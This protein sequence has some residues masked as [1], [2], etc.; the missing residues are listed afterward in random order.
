MSPATARHAIGTLRWA[1]AIFVVA[2]RGG[3]GARGLAGVPS[4]AQSAVA[5]E[6]PPATAPHH[7]KIVLYAGEGSAL[8]EYA[9]DPSTGDL[10]RETSLPLPYP[11]H[12]AAADPRSRFLYVSCSDS[13]TNHL[14]F[15]FAIDPVTGALT[16]RGEPLVPPGG[17]VIHLSV[18]RTGEHVV[19]AH[20]QTGQVAVVA[21]NADG[22]LGALV[23]Q[24]GDTA[25]GFF[26]H[27]SLLNPE[28]NGLVVCSVGGAATPGSPDVPGRLTVFAYERGLLTRTQ[29]LVLDAGAGP[30]HV[31]YGQGRVFVSAERSNRLLVYGYEGGVLGA[32]PLFDVSSLVDPSHV[33]PRQRAA[34]IHLHPSGRF[35]YQSNR[36]DFAQP[37]DVDGKATPVFVGGENSIAFYT[38]SDPAGEPTRVES[39]DTHGIEPRTFTIDPTGQLLVVGNQESRSV[40]DERGKLAEIPRSI[41][42]FRVASDGRLRLL[43]KVDVASGDVMWL[44]SLRLP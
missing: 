10:T 9:V 8:N 34:A 33:R 7:G 16:R 4:S 29:S 19:L 1:F 13:H 31:D 37:R 39:Y 35:L 5:A 30:R 26:T 11:V 43:H 42:V 15:A 28:G 12:Y 27:Q 6:G 24:P 38:L 22:S 41:A 21:V 17:R 3:A 2:C 40:V 32:A 20:P 44:D 18:D 23:Q 25:T 14:V 36:A